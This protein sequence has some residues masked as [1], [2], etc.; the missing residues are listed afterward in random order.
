MSERK[1]Y[2]KIE[3]I[4]SEALNEIKESLSQAPDRT[5]CF[6]RHIFPYSDSRELEEDEHQPSFGP[7]KVEGDGDHGQ[8]HDQEHDHQNEKEHATWVAGIVP[9]M[10]KK[11]RR[12]QEILSEE[13]KAARM[14]KHTHGSHNHEEESQLHSAYFGIQDSHRGLGLKIDEYDQTQNLIQAPIILSPGRNRFEDEVLLTNNAVKNTSREPAIVDIRKLFSIK[15]LTGQGLK[16]DSTDPEI[17]P[18][19]TAENQ[20]RPQVFYIPPLSNFILSNLPIL[21]A[22]LHRCGNPS[23][24]PHLPPDQKFN[25]IVLDPP[26]ANK[27][28][29]RS[30]HYKTQ[31]YSESELLAGYI[32]SVLAVHSHKPASAHLKNNSGSGSNLSI[33]AIWTTN[34]AKSRDVAYASLKAAGFSV[35]EEWIWVKTTAYGQPVTPIDG[36]WRKPYEMLVIGKRGWSGPELGSGISLGDGAAHVKA[37]GGNDE[38]DVLRR[39]IAAVTDVHSRKPNLK[40]VFERVFFTQSRPGGSAA[41]TTGEPV[42]YSALEVF[43]RNL[44]AGWWAVGNEVLKFNSEGWW[45]DVGGDS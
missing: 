26:W 15:T 2:E 45:V 14:N 20:G 7:N 17:D 13:R 11:K 27:S 34:S 28:V 25:L 24:I 22:P 5:W 4:V 36:V 39:V 44:T 10:R 37:A 32:R 23:P 16:A 1:L 41:A 42:R 30:K 8:K 6:H 29:Q 35:F 38:S 18:G 19:A 12:I 3:P 9:G 33:T 40:E 21:S 43:A 31:T